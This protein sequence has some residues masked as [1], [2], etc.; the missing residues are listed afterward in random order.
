LSSPNRST[1]RGGLLLTCGT[2]FICAATLWPL[3][4][5]F[6]AIG[7]R[8]F[9][10]A[11]A[12]EPSTLL[13]LPRNIILFVPFGIG[14]ASL[15]DGRR[16]PRTLNLVLTGAAGLAMTLSVESLQVF[17]P[18]RTPNLSDVWSNACGAVGGAAGFCAAPRMFGWLRA[19]VRRG[20][21]LTAAVIVSANVKLAVT[22]SL[23]LMTG[24]V[25]QPFTVGPQSPATTPRIEGAPIAAVRD[26][27]VLNRAADEAELLQLLDGR[28]PSELVDAIVAGP[29]H[30]RTRSA[31]GAPRISSS[32]TIALTLEPIGQ[33]AGTRGRLLSV[34]GDD[35]TDRIAIA[36]DETRMAL[37]W[38]SRFDGGAAARTELEFPGVL[39]PTPRPRRVVVT[40]R[41]VT[42][43]V[44]TSDGAGNGDVLLGP[45]ATLSA[46]LREAD[47]WPLTLRHIAFWRALITFAGVVFALPALLLGAILGR[48]RATLATACGILL[49]ALASETVVAIHGAHALRVAAILTGA[50]VTAAGFAAGRLASRRFGLQD[51]TQ[52]SAGG[53]PAVASERRQS[54]A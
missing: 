23:A 18:G 36:Q 12:F 24:I 49:P 2:L 43:S 14:V 22:V 44:R 5:A 54:T 45:E 28:V 19:S 53:F 50:A 42:A 51:E 39:E 16:V 32:F 47:Y 9:I 29:A 25:S 46:L 10:G 11:F 17:L 15:L 4:F 6:H 1:G 33:T 20:P 3:T 40:V 52:L 26:V 27:V 48:H 7:W 41:G 37:R 30:E 31:A 21:S 35:A 13:D 38:R 34:A 8:Q